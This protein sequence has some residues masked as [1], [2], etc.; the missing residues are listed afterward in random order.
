MALLAAFILWQV[1]ACRTRET[2]VGILTAA[3][4]AAVVPDIAFTALEM[5]IDAEERLRATGME[6]WLARLDPAA[7]DVVPRSPTGARLGRERMI[8]NVD[9]A[10]ETYLD[11]RSRAGGQRG[12]GRI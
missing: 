6:L 10:V 7:L 11:R 12:H 1:R 2:T 3:A 9:R 5:L 8:F 4:I